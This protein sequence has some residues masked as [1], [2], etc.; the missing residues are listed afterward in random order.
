MLKIMTLVKLLPFNENLLT[1]VMEIIASI[2][3]IIEFIQLDN[4]QLTVNAQKIDFKP[5]LKEAIKV[6]RERLE[7]T[8][9]GRVPNTIIIDRE[10]FQR[11]I[12]GI[13]RKFLDSSHVTISTWYTQTELNIIFFNDESINLALFQLKP[14]DSQNLSLNVVSKLCDLMNIDCVV[15][16]TCIT[17]TVPLKFGQN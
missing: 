14:M 8:I 2:N 15:E 3:N 9:T 1:C 7:A 10:K 12:I 5:C 11:I 4:N 16:K 17:I 13:T 6:G